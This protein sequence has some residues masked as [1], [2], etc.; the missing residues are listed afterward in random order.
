MAFVWDLLIILKS[1]KVE[2][3]NN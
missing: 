2:M 1:M 3:Q